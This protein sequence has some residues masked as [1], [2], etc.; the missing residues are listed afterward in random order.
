MPRQAQV[1]LEH[2]P[3]S[4]NLLPLVQ[5]SSGTEKLVREGK[6][7]LMIFRKQVFLRSPDFQ[8]VGLARGK[9]DIQSNT[10]M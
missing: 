9:Q 10:V 1:T 7:R 2:D 5:L 8:P 3:D 6:K 4:A